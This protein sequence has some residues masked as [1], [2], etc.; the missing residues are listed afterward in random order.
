[1]KIKYFL[2]ILA[3]IFVGF[4]FTKQQPSTKYKCMIQLTN[5]DGEGAYIVA[6][7]INPQGKYEKTLQVLGDDPEWYS[8][9]IEW[10]KF[11][12]KRETIDAITGA[13]ISGGERAVK[14]IEIEDDKI[15]K[16]Y[17]IRFETAV[18]DQKYY[19][20]D[21]EFELTSESVKSKVNGKGYI[22]YVRMMPN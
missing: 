14:V 11:Y 1:M 2:W 15:D 3:V 19:A 17:K 8:D 10:W 22:R 18:E 5:Y 21:V 6:S 20:T 16:G 7:L 9:L 4:S 12:G 13:T